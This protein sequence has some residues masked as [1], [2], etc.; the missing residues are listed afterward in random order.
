[1]KK[2]RIILFGSPVL[3]ETAK[4]VTVYH[5]KFHSL[6]D[7]MAETLKSRDDG[8]ALAANQV[9]ILKRVTVINYEGEYLELINPE[10]I[11]S[12][13]EQNGYEG[14]LSYPGYMG[15]VRRYDYVKVK[16]FNRLGEKKIIERFGK[17][18]RC[19]QH[20]IDHLN[21][22]LFI[23]KMEEEFLL[24]ADTENKI[25]R[26]TL[27]ELANGKNETEKFH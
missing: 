3:R 1:M 20:E 6:I 19:I 4:P 21:G 15:L 27:L 10:I 9:N 8:A 2:L 16:Y 13:G 26:S 14:C 23:D 7:S 18:S 25:S 12:A 5:K 22:I 17:L 24:H 11:E